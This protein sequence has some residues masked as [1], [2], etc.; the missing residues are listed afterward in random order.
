LA[1]RYA[2]RSELI[3]ETVRYFDSFDWRLHG[4][5]TTIV[6][7]A[8]G[9]GHRRAAGS[10][11]ITWESL[12]GAPHHRLPIGGVPDFVW[13]LPS[14]PA[15]DA[16]E[17]VLGVRRLLP[18]VTVRRRGSLLHLLDDDGKTVL[19][20]RLLER[21]VDEGSNLGE[22]LR[23]EPLKGYED[24]A[25]EV[26]ALLDGELAE[27][28]EPAR[29]LDEALSAIGRRAQDYTSKVAIRLDPEMPAETA[30]RIAHSS[31]LQTMRANERGVIEDLDSE[32]LHD[33]RVAVRRTRSALTQIKGV[34]PATACRRFRRAFSRLGRLTGPL[35]DLDVYLLRLRSDA[36]SLPPGE[37]DD[38]RPVE[39]L[40]DRE[41]RSEHRRL[42]RALSGRRYASLLQAWEEHLATPVS[43]HPSRP[44]AHRPILEVA[45]RRTWKVYRRVLAEG[46]QIGAATADQE[47]HRL[48]IEAKKLRYLMELFRTLYPKEIG[49]Q[50]K[51]L[52]GLQ[53]LLGDFNDAVV[54]ETILHS[55]SERLGA[56]AD[57]RTH[58]AL[59][60]LVEG[61]RRQRDDLR[62][63]FMEAFASFAATRNRAAC[64]ELFRR[65]EGV[66]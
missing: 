32:F 38:L 30:L 45:S 14:G 61:L 34:Y 8:A 18:L 22:V 64:R 15:R 33:F 25:R 56:R 65:P 57:P 5:G 49:S 9:D 48:R 31:L 24:R 16:L 46:E 37:R 27:T 51:A 35:R 53:D 59:G 13:E 55:I 29:E 66:A 36:E 47:L 17:P 41:R 28:A 62:A 43:S 20:L 19:R 50:I 2:L 39:E 44:A 6:D 3:D 7:T 54:Q 23:L 42:V 63:D 21:Q 4:C 12:A 40:L 60:R 11:S 26:E 1:A 52:K 10:S 58:V